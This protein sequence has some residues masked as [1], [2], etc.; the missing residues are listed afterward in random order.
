MKEFLKQHG[1]LRLLLIALFFLVGM[2]LTI[3]GWTMTG[4][5]AGLGIMVLGMILLLSA[6]LIYNK[7]YT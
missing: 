6:M 5:L 4:K 2:A 7:T 1:G 3:F